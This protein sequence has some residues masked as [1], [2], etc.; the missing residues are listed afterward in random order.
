MNVTDRFEDT[1]E[2]LS[3]L[4]GGMLVVIGLGTVAGAPWVTKVNLAT[5]AVQVIGALTTAAIGA[6]LAYLG[7][8]GSASP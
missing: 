3:L 2:P 7:W 6:G 4:V 5:A 1:L 8:Q